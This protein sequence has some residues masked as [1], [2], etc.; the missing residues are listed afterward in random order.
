[1]SSLSSHG[2]VI[3]SYSPDQSSSITDLD[4]TVKSPTLKPLRTGRDLAER[5]DEGVFDDGDESQTEEEENISP[6]A[7]ESDEEDEIEHF[8]STEFIMATLDETPAQFNEDDT[9]EHKCEQ[10]ESMEVQAAN[11]G[12]ACV[13]LSGEAKE[14]H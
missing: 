13:W 10:V 4:E 6:I 7:A 12:M 9:G 3:N 2:S 14:S 1:M 5:F 8:D 11:I